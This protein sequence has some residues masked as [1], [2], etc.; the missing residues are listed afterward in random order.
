MHHIFLLCLA[1]LIP[2][3]SIGGCG[4]ASDAY[5]KITPQEG[6]ELIVKDRITLIDV[7]EPAEY[8][9]GHIPSARLI[10]L[11][12]IDESITKTLPD[13]KS[14]LIVYCRSGVRSQKAAMKLV[15]LGYADVRDMGG[16][17]DWPYE[18]EK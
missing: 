15:E 17:K 4:T 11:G 13:K 6:H 18:I 16:I 7:R 1:F 12:T 10:P 14:P 3:L 5:H 2:V 8:K 9:E